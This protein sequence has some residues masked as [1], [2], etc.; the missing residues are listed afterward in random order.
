LAWKT[1]V[2]IAHSSHLSVGLHRNLLF[3]FLFA[4]FVQATAHSKLN[5]HDRALKCVLRAL[6]QIPGDVDMM[7][8]QAISLRALRKWDESIEVLEAVIKEHPDKTEATTELEISKAEKA[9]PPAVL[10]SPRAESSASPYVFTLGSSGR[11][12]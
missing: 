8:L 1:K 4:T 7:I 5:Q 12:D 9:H 3:P 11:L 6:H 2:R 10:E